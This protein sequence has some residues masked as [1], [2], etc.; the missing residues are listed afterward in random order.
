MCEILLNPGPLDEVKKK[1]K[2]KY[3]VVK[4][5]KNKHCAILHKNTSTEFDIELNLEFTTIENLQFV[6]GKGKEWNEFDDHLEPGQTS[7]CMLKPT[8]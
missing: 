7:F 2:E 6:N 1:E 4:M 3:S 5:W 8:N